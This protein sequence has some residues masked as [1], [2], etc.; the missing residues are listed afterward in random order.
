MGKITLLKQENSLFFSGIF[1]ILAANQLFD[2]CFHLSEVLSV[3]LLKKGTFI[4][5]VYGILIIVL[6]ILEIFVLK[7]ITA[8]Y[9][10]LLSIGRLLCISLLVVYLINSI[11]IYFVGTTVDMILIES[12]DQEI[13]KIRGSVGMMN[14]LLV[15]IH[16]IIIALTFLLG[17]KK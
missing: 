7:K 13:L 3:T 14:S 1:F 10:N 15:T 17:V 9:P 6:I 4:P 5:Y 2:V 12:R 11:L 16:N 8:A